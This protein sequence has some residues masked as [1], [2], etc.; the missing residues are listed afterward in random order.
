M[1]A[2]SV[3]SIHSDAVW[4]LYGCFSYNSRC[5]NDS[6]TASRLKARTFA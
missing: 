6:V 1:N 2:S 4:A 5:N 3:E